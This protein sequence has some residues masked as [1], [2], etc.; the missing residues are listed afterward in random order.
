MEKPN[1][2]PSK[3]EFSLVVGGPLYQLYLRGHLA[4][5]PLDLLHR[6]IL[7]F[8]LI[9][10]VPLFVLTVIGGKAFD[11]VHVPFLKDLAT[12]VRFLISI[13]LFLIGEIT[14]HNNI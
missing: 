6:R 4:Q 2:A 3:E 9:T 12:H 13:P 14:V 1:S 11:G 5:H 7:T 8:I 10:W